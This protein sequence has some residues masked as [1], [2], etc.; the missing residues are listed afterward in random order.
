[1]LLCAVLV[2]LYGIIRSFVD[3]KNIQGDSQPERGFAKRQWGPGS[4]YGH[5]TSK[6]QAAIERIGAKLQMRSRRVIVV[7]F[8][9]A[10]L[11][12]V[13]IGVLIDIAPRALNQEAPSSKITEGL[14]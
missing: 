6:F 9:V 12:G 4:N 3:Q 11:V 2:A 13:S 1:M 7:S 5:G 10:T 14:Q 8:L